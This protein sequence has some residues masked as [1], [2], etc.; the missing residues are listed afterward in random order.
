MPE[1]GEPPNDDDCAEFVRLT[2]TWVFPI[3]SPQLILSLCSDTACFGDTNWYHV[4]AQE[5]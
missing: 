1:A 4:V 3:L 2:K 5:V